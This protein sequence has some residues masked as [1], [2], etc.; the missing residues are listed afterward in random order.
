MKKD[1]YGRPY[2]DT[3]EGYHYPDDEKECAFNQCDHENISPGRDPFHPCY[4]ND[5]GNEL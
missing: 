3:C 2:C 5:C 1:E 4:C